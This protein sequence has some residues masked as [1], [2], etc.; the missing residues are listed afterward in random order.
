MLMKFTYSHNHTHARMY[1]RTHT[2][3]H[4]H[5]HTTRMHAHTHIHTEAWSQIICMHGMGKVP[6]KTPLSLYI[7]T[8]VDYFSHRPFQPTYH[9]SY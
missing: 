6:S 2:R 7:Y 3:M 4:T 8:H 1:A 9:S 5:T